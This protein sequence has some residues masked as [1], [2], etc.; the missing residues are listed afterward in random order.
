MCARSLISI[1]KSSDCMALIAST[2]SLLH[3]LTIT[4]PLLDSI[5]R[6]ISATSGG[7]LPSANMTSGTP[8]RS[9]RL[10]SNFA[11]QPNASIVDRR[12]IFSASMGEISL[13]E[14]LSKISL[15]VSI[16]R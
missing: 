2:C 12:S 6:Q 4:R 1:V 10:A 14:T 11:K 8:F 5:T 7:V 15:S 3:R 16:N 13:R 9:S